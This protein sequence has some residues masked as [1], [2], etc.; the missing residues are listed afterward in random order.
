VVEV[1]G[2]WLRVVVLGS[3]V[4]RREAGSDWRMIP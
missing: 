3:W 4:P 2:E 1:S